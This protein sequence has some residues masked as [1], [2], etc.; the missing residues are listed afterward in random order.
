MLCALQCAYPR[1]RVLVTAPTH[2]AVDNVMRKYVTRIRNSPILRAQQPHPLRVSSEVRKVTEDLRAFTCDAAAGSEVHSNHRAMDKAKKLIKQC[3]AAFT[4]CIGAGVGLLRREM[5]DI[6]IVD[7]A[8]Q[9]T[10]P[11]SL[12]PLFKGCAKAILVGDHVQLR[13]TVNQHALAVDF[14]ISLFERLFLRSIQTDPAR[15]DVGA[16]TGSS[17]DG[18]KTLMLDTQYRM[19]PDIC[20][21]SSL[22]FY[23]GKLRSGVTGGDRPLFRSQFPFPSLPGS[24]E[25]GRA[26]FVECAAREAMGQMSKENAGQANLCKHI[27]TLLTTARDREGKDNKNVSADTADQTV[28]VLAPYSRQVELPQRVLSDVKGVEISSIDGFQG[29]E[30]DVVVF[31]TV[32][33]NEHRDIGFLKDLRRMNV[34]LTGARTAL[35]VIGNRSTLTEGDADDQ[36]TLDPDLYT[37]VAQTIA[38]TEYLFARLKQIGVG[39]IHGLPG[40]FNLTLLDY[41]EPCGLTWVGKANELNDGETKST[42]VPF[43]TLLERGCELCPPL[44]TPKG[45]SFATKNLTVRDTSS[46]VEGSTMHQGSRAAL[47]E[48]Y[49]SIRSA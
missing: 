12:V 33:C 26:V 22:E 47:L 18:L 1:A 2:N 32:R 16:E 45:Q 21:F 9:Q 41:V 8:S 7:E 23:N 24:H 15:E 31:I 19:H 17:V 30:A 6:V 5:F 14:D 29:R 40:D 3:D 38:L 46:A 48:K 25:L 35:I 37:I 4:T 43:S 11:A 36:S 13:P 49:V 39:A 28:A 20:E 10:E 34:A 27:C 42:V 44:R